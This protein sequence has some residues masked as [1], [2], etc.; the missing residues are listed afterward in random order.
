LRPLRCKHPRSIAQRSSYRLGNAKET[1]AGKDFFIIVNRLLTIA[2]TIHRPV[3]SA[4]LADRIDAAE[5][6]NG[7]CEFNLRLGDYIVLTTVAI[8][9]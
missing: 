5:R 4:V 7:W 2:N 1:T 3:A 9:R 6:P 8:G